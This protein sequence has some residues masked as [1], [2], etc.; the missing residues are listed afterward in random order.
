MG[1]VSKYKKIK[2]IDPFCPASRVAAAEARKEALTGKRKAN[3]PYNPKRDKKPSR[4]FMALVKSTKT[5]A[6]EEAKQKKAKEL[7]RRQQKQQK[8]K[9]GGKAQP[10]KPAA[11]KRKLTRGEAMTDHRFEAPLAKKRH[12]RD[13]EGG[14]E[15]ESKIGKMIADANGVNKY[16]IDSNGVKR[17]SREVKRKEWSKNKKK[18][19]KQREKTVMQ[20]EERVSLKKEKIRR[21]LRD[22][23]E[24]GVKSE[25]DNEFREFSLVPPKFSGIEKLDKKL[26]K[27]KAKATAK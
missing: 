15:P 26:D 11:G 27:L 23:I 2:V 9:G 10:K 5:L 6:K 22:N 24:E 13:E 19:R 7:Q 16:M 8:G 20:M 17:T 21:N 4:A 12:N 18:Q 3:T 25:N 14:E 1:R